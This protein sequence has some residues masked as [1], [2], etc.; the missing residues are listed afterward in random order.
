MLL[1]V[2][3][4]HLVVLLRL[5]LQVKTVWSMPERFA[6]CIVKRRYINTLPF[7]SF[8]LRQCERILSLLVSITLVQC[9]PDLVQCRHK[10]THAQINR[11][12]VTAV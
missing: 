1:A 7:L 11:L 3:D 2:V 4:Y 5:Y 10:V 12:R 9:L 6:Y 8:L